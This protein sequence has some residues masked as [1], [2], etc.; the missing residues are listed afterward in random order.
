[1]DGRLGGGASVAA[2]DRGGGHDWEGG[3]GLLMRRA[4]GGKADWG[5]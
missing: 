2:E 5:S 1:M 3:P 4:R